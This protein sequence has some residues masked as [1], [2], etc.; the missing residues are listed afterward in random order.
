MCIRDRPHIITLN[1]SNIVYI[2]I[3]EVKQPGRLRE[4][5]LHLKI[6]T[7]EFKQTWRRGRRERHVKCDSQDLFKI[8]HQLLKVITLT[9]CVLTILK[10]NWSQRF[11]GKKTKLSIC[12]HTPTLSTKLQNGSFTSW[13]ERECLWNVQKWKMHVQS[14]P[15]YSFSFLPSSSW[16]PK[17]PICTMVTILRLLLFACILSCWQITLKVER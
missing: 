12:H 16:L 4:I 3:R 7:K 11:T 1:W 8:N 6:G 17:L 15:N 9:K 2:S 5:E 10:L 14:V 13:K